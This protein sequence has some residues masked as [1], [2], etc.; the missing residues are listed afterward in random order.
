MEPVAIRI[1]HCLIKINR[2]MTA[3]SAMNFTD[4]KL[5][6]WNLR[7]ILRGQAFTNLKSVLA[8][9]KSRDGFWKLS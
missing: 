9:I 4:H 8:S 5:L 6:A 2:E 7:L 3:A 1:D